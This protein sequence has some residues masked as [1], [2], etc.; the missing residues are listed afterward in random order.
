MIPKSEFL[1][2]IRSVLLDHR[3]AHT[4]HVRLHLRQREPGLDATQYLKSVAAAA[5]LAQ[6]VGREGQ[7]SPDLSFIRIGESIR[8]HSHHRHRNAVN[9]NRASDHVRIPAKYTPP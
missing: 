9:I 3:L 4:V 7:W 1:V 6:I 5:V 8:H 2:W